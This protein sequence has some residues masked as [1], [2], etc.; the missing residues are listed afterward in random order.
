MKRSCSHSMPVFT[1][2]SGCL[3]NTPGSSTPID[4]HHA[5]VWEARY[6]RGR[7]TLTWMGRIAGL[8]VV[9]SVLGVT[10]CSTIGST[11]RTT[12]TTLTTSPAE[13]SPALSGATTTTTMADAEG[14]SSSTVP[15][16]S[17][18][19]KATVLVTATDPSRSQSVCLIAGGKLFVTLPG[20]SSPGTGPWLS[21]P[22]SL[23]TS[24][25]EPTATTDAGGIYVSHFTAIGAGNTEIRASY[26]PCA[27]I[28]NGSTGCSLPL[29]TF[30]ILV[31]VT[32]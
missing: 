5:A 30:Q 29:L 4:P 3:P 13:R 1:T 21:A 22:E 25:V 26:A 8:A 31:K 27:A 23:N 17:R 10:G 20:K 9:M 32:S 11:V 15:S 19:V 12:T 24:V 6:Q 7:A 18:C 28:A 16:S 14:T 2:L